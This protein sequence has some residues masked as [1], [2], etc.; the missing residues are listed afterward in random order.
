MKDKVA[1][2]TGA[3]SGIGRA[4]ALL[5]ARNGVDVVAVGRNEGELNALRDETRESSGSVKIHLGDI[6][7]RSTASGGSTSSS[8]PPA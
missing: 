1:V 4:T 8:T 7:R 6:T 5:F 2:V 3:S